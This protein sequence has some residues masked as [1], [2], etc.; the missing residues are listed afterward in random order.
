MAV[1]AVLDELPVTLVLDG[2]AAGL[3]RP[4]R[5]FRVVRLFHRF[6][7]LNRVVVAL[8]K[9]ILPVF[10]A[11]MLLIV[12]TAAFAVAGVYCRCRSEPHAVALPELS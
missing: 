9:S 10:N 3:I 6:R 4:M 5:V 2:S 8:G 11:M 12:T 7:S 1:R